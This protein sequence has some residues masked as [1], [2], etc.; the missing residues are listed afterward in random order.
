VPDE[1]QKTKEYLLRVYELLRDQTAVVADLTMLLTSLVAALEDHPELSAS[2]LAAQN[3]K[4]EV[5]SAIKL[6]S[7]DVLDDAI[8]KL[9]QDLNV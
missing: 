2:F 5:T 4:L 1:L 7:L 3:R 8:R 6:E 9:R